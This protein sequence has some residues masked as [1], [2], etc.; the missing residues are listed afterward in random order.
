MQCLAPQAD[1]T[2]GHNS[3]AGRALSMPREAWFHRCYSTEATV[4]SRL[5]H[6]AWHI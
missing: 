2:Q 6:S 1:S 5:T 3:A 4:G